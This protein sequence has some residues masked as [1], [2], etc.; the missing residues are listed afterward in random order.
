MMIDNRQRRGDSFEY[1]GV[2]GCDMDPDFDVSQ[3]IVLATLRKAHGGIVI[4]PLTVTVGALRI[5]NGL[6]AIPLTITASY[7]QTATWPL[8][9]VSFD[10]Q[11]TYKT[12]RLSSR[13]V[14]INVEGDDTV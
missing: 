10:V 3:L 5:E 9:P 7:A 14:S 13:H 2:I 6:Y 8:G 4:Q 11:V 12:E 1:L